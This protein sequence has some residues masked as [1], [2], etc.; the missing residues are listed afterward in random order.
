MV[1]S[2]TLGGTLCAWLGANG[3]ADMMD[4]RIRIAAHA[5]SNADVRPRPKFK[6]MVFCIQSIGSRPLG[7][8]PRFSFFT[9]F[10]DRTILECAACRLLI[11][12]GHAASSV[13][14]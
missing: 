13:S 6:R 1:T 3:V 4:A 2:S 10:R 12:V 8:L 14:A 7:R 11:A 5:T 9:G